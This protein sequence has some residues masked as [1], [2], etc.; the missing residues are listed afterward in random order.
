VALAAPRDRGFNRLAW[1]FPYSVA[2]RRRRARLRRVPAGQAAE[3]RRPRR[4]NA[5]VADQELADKLDDEL[6][7]LD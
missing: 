2:T 4:A 5:D 6:R 3:P 1:L 7:N